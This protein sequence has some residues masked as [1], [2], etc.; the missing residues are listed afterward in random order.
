MNQRSAKEL[1]TLYR[2]PNEDL[3]LITSFKPHFEK[4]RDQLIE[5]WYKWLETTPE[6]EEI[7]EDPNILKHARKQQSNYWSEFFKGVLDEDYLAY[8]RKIGEIHARIGLPLEIYLAGVEYFSELILGIL[9][10][11]KLTP[12]KIYSLR[13]AIL[14]L[15][16]I[17]MTTIVQSYEVMVNSKIAAQSKLLLE[18]STPVTQLWDGLLLLPVVGLIDSKRAQDIMNNSL[19][20]I[21]ETHAKSFILDISGVAV[22]DT[23]VANHLI[24]ITKATKLMGCESIISGVSPSIAQTI[25]ELGIDV[26]T[27]KTTSDMKAALELSFINLGMKI[28]ATK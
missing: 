2:L 25:V 5:D 13:I 6:Y 20:K 1:M 23:A 22:V 11:S 16:S 17:D 21:F 4:N 19:A 26:G 14:K 18:M 9:V 27:M 12:K 15:T 10:N 7:F 8:R 3:K 28:T 24:K